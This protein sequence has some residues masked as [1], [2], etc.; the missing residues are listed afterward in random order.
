MLLAP[1]GHLILA[2]LGAA[3][4]ARTPDGA[5]RRHA[6]AVGSGS[7]MAP[8]VVAKGKEYSSHCDMWSAGVIIFALISGY[9]PFSAPDDDALALKIRRGEYSRKAEIW[10]EV[11][12]EAEDFV[13][14]LLQVSQGSRPSAQAAL[15]HP[16]LQRR[17]Q[18]RCSVSHID[19]QITD[20]LCEFGEI[21]TFR[22]CCMEMM[23]WCL[24]NEDRSKV[25]QIFMA[26]DK[27]HQGTINLDEFQEAFKSQQD[28]SV[29]EL[30]KAFKRLDTNQDREIHYSDF[31]AAM[32]SSQIGI[33]DDL[34]KLC[35]RRFD[36][37]A[38]GYITQK[39]LLAVLGEKFEGEDVEK[40][41]A[42]ADF[43]HDGQI[44]YPEFV[45]YLRGDPLSDTAAK[46]KQP[47]GMAGLRSDS[48]TT[49]CTVSTACTSGTVDC[50]EPPEADHCSNRNAAHCQSSKC[51][52]VPGHEP[53]SRKGK[54]SCSLLPSFW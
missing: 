19:R 13:L 16:W 43:L 29:R 54:M 18:Q 47:S 12:P 2:D 32:V 48:K 45:T 8:E 51:G 20:A 38:T 24:S 40:L 23:A 42:E 37:D 25:R 21:S 17:H 9:M 28:V 3:A 52:T 31:L 33:N 49:S 30:L 22:R 41:L 6:H 5:M 15:D 53:K 50:V 44:S 36:S 7:Y 46:S 27:N 39:N 34:L 14:S 1:Q 11:S 35:F 4:P 26:M 10:D